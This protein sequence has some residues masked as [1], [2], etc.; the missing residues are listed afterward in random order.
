MMQRLYSAFAEG[1][2]CRS[3]SRDTHWI[4]AEGM[5]YGG[6]LPAVFGEAAAN[7][8]GPITSDVQG[9][10]A[11][12]DEIIPAGEDRVLALSLPRHGSRRGSRSALCSPL[13][14]PRWSHH[15]PVVQRIL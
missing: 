12:P 9:S 2:A 4:E 10:A 13:D 8:F 5:T 11:K 6:H 1:D 7:A 3:C 14:G 15:E